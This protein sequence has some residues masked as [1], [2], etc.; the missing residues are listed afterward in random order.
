[1]EFCRHFPDTEKLI[2]DFFDQFGRTK[3]KD[4]Y[5]SHPGNIAG[6]KAKIIKGVPTEDQ[7]KRFLSGIDVL[8][9]IETPYNSQTYHFARQMGVKT[10]LRLN[11]EWLDDRELEF[12]HPDLFI[13]P[14]LYH[15]DDIPGPK[16]Y[17]PFPI[18][19]D[20]LPG[21]IH[22]TAKH[23][24]HIAGNCKASYDRNGTTALI[25]AL[26]FIKSDI[27]ITIKS[28]VNFENEITDKR[29]ILD[30][31]SVDNYWE[32]YPDDADVLILP[33][34]YAGQSLPINEA[35]AKGMA[36]I[37]TD[38]DPQNDFLHQAGLI[39][40]KFEKSVKIK[41]HI[42]VA[43]IDPQDL[44]RTIDRVAGMDIE[45]LS[46]QSLMVADAWSWDNLKDKYQN[47]FEKLCR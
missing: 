45:P 29:F 21:R 1:M 10:V 43:A 5:K 32:N 46:R 31:K 9:T 27:K 12:G 39:P 28:Q 42:D 40:I 25:K 3:D 20:R 30:P 36:I 44:A 24:I 35:M 26:R 15:F 2:I 11:Y 19:T 16:E 6:P 4:I 13:A 14:S 47:I 17:L 38:M 18:A 34:R 7:I 37:S 23:F 22:K 41:Q 8:F 33:R